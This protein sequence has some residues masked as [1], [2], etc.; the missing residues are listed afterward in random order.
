MNQETHHMIDENDLEPF[1]L[2]QL[3]KYGN[4]LPGTGRRMSIDADGIIRMREEEEQK[5]NEHFEKRLD[6]HLNY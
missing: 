3:R 6:D 5:I 4:I 2:F 1:E